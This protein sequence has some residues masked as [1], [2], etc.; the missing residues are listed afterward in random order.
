[1]PTG[2]E[3]AGQLQRRSMQFFVLLNLLVVILATAT[4]TSPSLTRTSATTSTM[5]HSYPF[6]TMW[7]YL[8]MLTPG[9]SPEQQAL[10]VVLEQ[11]RQFEGLQDPQDLCG[12]VV[13]L[14]FGTAG[15]KEAVVHSS[16]G[17]NPPAGADVGSF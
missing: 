8:R 2:A 5:G 1:M 16:V 13:N 6:K 10:Q 3:S 11:Q 4:T 9:T 14:E 17:E 15:L 7:A 12:L